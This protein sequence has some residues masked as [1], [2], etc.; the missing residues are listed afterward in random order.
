MEEAVR[1]AES[2]ALAKY[3]KVEVRPAY[4]IRSVP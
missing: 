3:A 2:S 1:M 4:D